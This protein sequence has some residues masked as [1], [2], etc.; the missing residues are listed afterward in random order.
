VCDDVAE[1]DKGW[2]AV[3]DGL[4]RAKTDEATPVN[5]VIA[6]QTESSQATTVLPQSTNAMPLLYIFR[7]VPSARSPKEGNNPGETA[8]RATLHACLVH[9]LDERVFLLDEQVLGE[10]AIA[11]RATPWHFEPLAETPRCHDSR[12][13][14][15]RSSVPPIARNP[16]AQTAGDLRHRRPPRHGAARDH[17]SGSKPARGAARDRSDRSWS[18][19]AAR[20]L[21][22]NRDHDSPTARTP[23]ASR[24]PR[25]SSRTAADKKVFSGMAG[26]MNGR[27]ARRPSPRPLPA[28]PG[29]SPQ[30]G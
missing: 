4:N 3:C 15:R 6:A 2:Q 10:I 12:R 29:R 14:I 5:R 13:S 8:A 26:Q 16:A 25:R 9:R 28:G 11:L 19:L 7:G 22:G 30:V 20:S 27:S 18:N 1:G 24:L 17:R 23:P 21:A